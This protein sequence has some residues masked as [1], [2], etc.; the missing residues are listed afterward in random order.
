ME[1][2]LVVNNSESGSL[3]QKYT[4]RNKETEDL[5]TEAHSC[6]GQV[7][8]AGRPHAFITSMCQFTEVWNTHGPSLGCPA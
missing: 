5:G 8:G 2:E 6:M 4:V 1:M 7:A 3:T